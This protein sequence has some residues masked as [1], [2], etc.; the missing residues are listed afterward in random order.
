MKI[1]RLHTLF[2]LCFVIV[3]LAVGVY[4]GA[5]GNHTQQVTHAHILLIGFVL[6]LL[7]ASIYRLWIPEG[8]SKLALAQLV[9]HHLGAVGLGVALFMLFG[10]IATEASLGPLLGIA[11]NAVLLAAV[12]MLVIFLRSAKAG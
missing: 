5:S 10:Q 4:M 8:P 9:L 1:A 6:S 12:L 3:G 7:Y 11:S 2:G